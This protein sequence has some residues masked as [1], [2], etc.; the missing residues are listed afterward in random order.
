M[1]NQLATCCGL[2]PRD[3]DSDG[4]GDSSHG[5]GSSGYGHYGES[6]GQ[7]SGY[8]EGVF[9]D[10]T[11]PLIRYNCKLQVKTVVRSCLSTCSFFE[12]ASEIMI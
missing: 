11:A 2:C 3:G 8:D 9:S 10:D 6:G 7:G 1:G 12:N 5:D 4:H